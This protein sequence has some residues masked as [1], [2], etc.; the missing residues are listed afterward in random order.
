MAN[1]TRLKHKFE[2]DAAREE[3]R[4]ECIQELRLDFT[5]RWGSGAVVDLTSLSDRPELASSMALALF[6]FCEPNEQVK[7]F[8]TL[9]AYERR[10]KAYFWPFLSAYESDGKP[11]I[12]RPQDIKTSTLRAFINWL[13]LK[14]IRLGTAYY[15]YLVITRIIS[16]LRE[17][18]PDLIDAALE[19]PRFPIEGVEESHIPRAPYSE[20]EALEI[21]RAARKEIRLTILRLK[22]GSE[23]LSNSKDPRSENNWNDKGNVLWYVK[24]VLGGE[25]LTRKELMESNHMALAYAFNRILPTSKREIY[26]YLYPL[27]SDL[28]P[29]LI[30][31]SIKTGFNPQPVIDLSRN[32][33]K[34]VPQSG[35]VG[36]VATKY[37][38]GGAGPKT[39]MRV[40][41]DRSS[42]GPG[43]IIR[44]FLNL[45]E[46]CL[47]FIP[48]EDHNYLW[49]GLQ[50]YYAEGFQRLNNLRLIDKEVKKFAARNNLMGDDGKPLS[51]R[52]AR[53][54]TTWMTKRYKASGNLA[55]VSKD[56]NHAQTSTTRNYINNAQTRPIHERT[57]ADG[58][59]D[60]YNAVRGRVLLQR[61]D[62]PDQVESA[63]QI[64]ETTVERAESMLRGEQ[65]TFVSS[66][67]D[68]YNRPG[69]PANTPC[70]RPWACFT[71]KNAYWTSRMLPRLIRF[72][73]FLVAQRTLL[74][75]EDWRAKFGLPYEAITRYIL[76]AFPTEVVSEARLTAEADQFLVPFT[77]KTV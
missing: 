35:K 5:D 23:L 68:F 47:Q 59:Q 6:D 20:R 55:A 3:R 4:R 76:P 50:P 17:A 38:T 12:L 57:I 33:L 30:I 62:D 58:L 49:V 15:A 34:A 45:T 56:A 75:A 41:D 24:N 26:S 66:C 51:L 21:E 7:R 63:A 32:C 52:L 60:F 73:D 39:Y 40:V 25:Y 69:G 22:Q 19:V 27:I 1:P 37:R 43:E 10:I 36:I 2:N 16:H 54:R 9:E 71:C 14:K 31:I 29:A 42:L 72:L 61:P 64:T 44:T 65:D 11:R 53:L 70:D 46:R 67:K 8:R 74:T 77:L 48:T 28:I 13:R 18:Y